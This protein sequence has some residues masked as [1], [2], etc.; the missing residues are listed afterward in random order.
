MIKRLIIIGIGGIGIDLVRYL[1]AYYEIIAIDRCPKVI[2]EVQN[3]YD[4]QAIVG[5][6]LDIEVLSKL[7]LG[8]H[9]GV[10]SVTG[11]DET[12]LTV[13]N[14]VRRLFPVKFVAVRLRNP[15]LHHPT[16][17]EALKKDWGINVILNVE[18]CIANH[19]FHAAHYPG[20][21]RHMSFFEKKLDGIIIKVTSQDRICGMTIED[22]EQYN[23]PQGIR[24]LQVIRQKKMCDVHRNF[25]LQV[26]DLV[27]LLYH[28]TVV[29]K[30]FFDSA[31]YLPKNIVCFGTEF[32][33]FALAQLLH[34][35]YAGDVFFLDAHG[36]NFERLVLQYPEFSFFRLCSLESTIWHNIRRDPDE[37]VVVALGLTDADNLL[38][39]LAHTSAKHSV[40]VVKNS[41]YLS[42]CYALGVHV[43]LNPGL[44]IVEVLIKSL[45]PQCVEEVYVLQ[46]FTTNSCEFILLIT[47]RIEEEAP[48]SQMSQED[49]K[50]LALE[51][52]AV[53]RKKKLIFKPQYFIPQDLIVMRCTQ[54]KYAQL[55]DLVSPRFT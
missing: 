25:V 12:N 44:L 48:I 40:T 34:T 24:V 4:I 19:A 43:I 6:A 45:S 1:Q 23:V 47:V 27:Y 36:K 38:A 46:D 18:S 16:F 7:E 29:L 13:C 5:D 30:R 54:S 49:L 50:A 39:C 35:H 15:T 3:K 9:C 51:I 41:A 55:L 21:V 32:F 2:L 28:P 22:I 10:I 42:V 26:G 11:K 37:S 14:F 52:V 53:F 20:I 33:S 17:S 31:I 8:Q